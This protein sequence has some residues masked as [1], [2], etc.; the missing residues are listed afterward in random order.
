MLGFGP[1]GGTNQPQENQWYVKI[2]YKKQNVS[3]YKFDFKNRKS[4]EYLP[5][6]RGGRLG[7]NPGREGST[8]RVELIQWVG[9]KWPTHNDLYFGNT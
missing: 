9:I 2:I 5:S 8:R 7:S 6:S 1:F 3:N 4:G